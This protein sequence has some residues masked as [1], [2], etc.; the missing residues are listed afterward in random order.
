MRRQ[1]AEAP[2]ERTKAHSYLRSKSEIQSLVPLVRRGRKIIRLLLRRHGIPDPSPLLI[3]INIECLGT[4][5]EHHIVDADTNQNSITTSIHGLIIITINLL[6][7]QYQ[8]IMTAGEN[9]HFAQ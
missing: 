1:F 5:E 4:N 7:C 8:D 9:L 6:H 2:Q 3:D